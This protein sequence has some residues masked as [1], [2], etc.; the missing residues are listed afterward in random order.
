MAQRASEL[1][2]LARSLD[3]NGFRHLLAGADLH[4]FL[5][6]ANALQ[7]GMD[8]LSHQ[9]QDALLAGQPG[10][11]AARRQLADVAG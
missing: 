5:K 11:N 1:L 4:T 7:H 2:R 10:S 3:P 9:R 6:T 8:E